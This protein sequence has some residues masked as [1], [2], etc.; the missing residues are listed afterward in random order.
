MKS[1]FI[2]T[3]DPHPNG[4]YAVMS[5]WVFEDGAPSLSSIVYSGGDVADW[6]D[7][8]AIEDPRG[9]LFHGTSSLLWSQTIFSA[10]IVAGQLGIPE[11]LWVKS[12]DARQTLGEL[13]GYGK[14]PRKDREVKECLQ[15]LYGEDCF[16]REKACRKAKNKSHGKDCPLCGGS[17]A[18]RLEGLL[19]DLNTS[20]YRDAFLVAL[21]VMTKGLYK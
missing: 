17:G 7:F 13:A 20:H 2:Q 6:S 16:L 8:S 15:A 10:G 4:I 14:T 11:K 9:V 19:V 3:F 18:E 21:H 1:V 5:V 12:Q